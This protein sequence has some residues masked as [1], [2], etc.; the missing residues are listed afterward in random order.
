[1]SG[2]VVEQITSEFHD[3]YEVQGGSRDGRLLSYSL[4]RGEDAPGGQQLK[5]HTLD[6]HTGSTTRMP[7]AINNSG[8]FSPDG[9]Y[10]VVAANV[11]QT[12]MQGVTCMGNP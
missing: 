12:P 3:E 9:E 5:V 7:E 6:L 8:A 10:L 4:N 1:M 11:Y 2:C